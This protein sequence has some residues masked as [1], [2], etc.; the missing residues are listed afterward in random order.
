MT[1]GQPGIVVVWLSVLCLSLSP[2]PVQDK[3]ALACPE[4][5][6][7]SSLWFMRDDQVKRNSEKYY[8]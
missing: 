6:S 2:V 8:R 7:V 4:G 1:N 3:K 5:E